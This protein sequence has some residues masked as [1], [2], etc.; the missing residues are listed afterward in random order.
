MTE[1][2]RHDVFESI[3]VTW[4]HAVVYLFQYLMVRQ[5]ACITCAVFK[6]WSTRDNIREKM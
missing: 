4:P 5:P 6:L 2:Y 1:P 3:G